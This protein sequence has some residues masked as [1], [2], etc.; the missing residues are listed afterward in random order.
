MHLK[1]IRYSRLER[2]RVDKIVFVGALW[3]SKCGAGERKRRFA[4]ASGSSMLV[5]INELKDE[6]VTW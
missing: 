5:Q 3:A 2:A 6:M 4:S 1:P